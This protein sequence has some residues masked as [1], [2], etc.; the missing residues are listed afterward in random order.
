MSHSYAL[1]LLSESYDRK[2]TDGENL[3]LDSAFASEPELLKFKNLL[4]RIRQVHRADAELEDFLPFPQAQL[5]D[6]R[7]LEIESLIQ[8]ALDD[9]ASE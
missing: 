1:Q 5:S 4:D 9:H 8:S 3:I 7:K 2:L 6:K